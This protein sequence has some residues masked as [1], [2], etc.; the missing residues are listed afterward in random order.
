[1]HHQWAINA[2]CRTIFLLPL[3]NP[4]NLFMTLKLEVT[5]LES[6]LPNKTKLSKFSSGQ[7]SRKGTASLALVV[8]ARRSPKT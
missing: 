7:E 5:L 1:M 2:N 3:N 4:D 6:L 8:C